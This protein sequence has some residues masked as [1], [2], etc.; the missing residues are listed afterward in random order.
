MCLCVAWGYGPSSNRLWATEIKVASG[1]GVEDIYGPRNIFFLLRRRAALSDS[2]KDIPITL[3]PFHSHSPSG[4][5]NPPVSG[6]KGSPVTLWTQQLN[7]LAGQVKS[8]ASWF[9]VLA[10][11]WTDNNELICAKYLCFDNRFINSRINCFSW[12]WGGSGTPETTRARTNP[13]V[14][15][16]VSYQHPLAGLLALN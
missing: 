7:L 4:R 3:C 9:M 8:L 10:S 13:H 1:E 16:K 6:S 11:C 14:R 12:L 5:N 2:W 15:C